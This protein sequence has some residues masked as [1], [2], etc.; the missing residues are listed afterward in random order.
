MDISKKKE[1]DRF[2]LRKAA[3]AIQSKQQKFLTLPP[4]RKASGFRN[5]KYGPEADL[6]NNFIALARKSSETKKLLITVEK[7]ISPIFET[8]HHSDYNL[9]FIFVLFATINTSVN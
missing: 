2:L 9:C 4:T 6:E 7:Q 3:E 8:N 1:I 5:Q